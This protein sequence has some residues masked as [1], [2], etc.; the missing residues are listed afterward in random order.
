M[1][2]NLPVRY[3]LLP[4]EGSKGTEEEIS[5]AKI[6]LF[7]G[8]KPKKKSVCLSHEEMLAIDKLVSASQ[9]LIDDI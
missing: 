9:S 8:K 2:S 4:T 1:L 7:F 5:F 6:T 3:P